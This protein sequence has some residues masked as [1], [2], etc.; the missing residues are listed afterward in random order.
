VIR[1]A[2][3]FVAGILTFAYVVALFGLTWLSCYGTGLG[4]DNGW[5]QRTI[6]TA[7]YLA[8]IGLMILLARR[9]LRGEGGL[10]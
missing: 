3:V 1:A 10:R 8:A 4:C 2:A 6:A 9:S 5:M 7:V